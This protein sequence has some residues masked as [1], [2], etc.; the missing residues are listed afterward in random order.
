MLEWQEREHEQDDA[1]A[2]GN[3]IMMNALRECG[4]YKFFM[5]PNMHSHPMLLQPLVDM[6][7]VEAGHFMVGDQFFCLEMKYFYF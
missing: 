1:L 2:L 6:W 7:D 5:C 4:I 3:D